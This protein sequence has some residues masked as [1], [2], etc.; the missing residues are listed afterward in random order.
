MTVRRIHSFV[1]CAVWRSRR[2]DFHGRKEPSSVIVIRKARADVFLGPDSFSLLLNVQ[3]L[4]Y[5]ADK[6]VYRGDVCLGNDFEIRVVDKVL[7]ISETQ[8]MIVELLP[9]GS[10]LLK[11]DSD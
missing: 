8:L 4:R 1:R 6:S 11:S 10:M 2:L 7:D 9:P 3:P 5:D